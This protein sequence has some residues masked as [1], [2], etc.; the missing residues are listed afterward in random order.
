MKKIPQSN[1][2][3]L[4]N[5]IL[6]VLSTDFIVSRNEARRSFMGF[7]AHV[8]KYSYEMTW[9]HEAVSTDLNMFADGDVSHLMLF[10]PPQHGKSELSSRLLPA[11]LLG[12][13]PAY[14]LAIVCYS[15]VIAQGFSNDVQQLIA[16]DVYGEIFPETRIDGVR[17]IKV[18]TLKR[19][20]Y[21]VQTDKGGYLISVGIGGP[22]TSKT[23]DIAII[24]D[25]YKDKL[26]AWSSAW[27]KNV[28]DWY[29]S[30]LE[31]RLHND[32]RVL[33]LY[34]R[35][36]EDDLAGELLKVEPAKWK[37]VKYEILK[38]RLTDNPRDTRVTGEALWPKKHSAESALR[39]KALDEISFE[40]MGQ[41]NPKPVKGF[42]YPRHKT[43]TEL[44][45]TSGALYV[46]K[47]YG[48]T[49]DDG[50]DMYAGAAYLEIDG[51]CYILD[52]IYTQEPMEVTEPITA[53]MICEC[54]VE[55]ALI[56]SNNGGKGFAR[57]VRS[58][59][60]K[61]PSNHHCY[62]DWFFQSNNKVARIFSNAAKVMNRIV[63]PHDWA[64]RWPEAYKHFNSYMR[65]GKNEHDDLE[66]MLTGMVEH[67]DTEIE[68]APGICF[69]GGV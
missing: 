66:D 63:W 2:S 37:Q 69:G 48:D 56:E 54:E 33:I 10:A 44:P 24:D 34:T 43:Y 13:N 40:S 52:L 68:G 64:E 12:K 38:T 18:G 3:K 1:R 67:I 11:Y 36:H 58:Y 51:L 26:S 4:L 35:W 30:V 47:F 29:F 57:Q 7:I 31:R 50:S 55:S 32:S 42:M 16:S 61:H 45:D 59:I 46:R 27:R 6:N 9:F 60:E 17:G 65:E 23:V 14:K 28:W 20:S 19:N 8:R 49:A 22:L 15:G 39:W 41:Q 62:V 53:D 5:N 25:L 21:E